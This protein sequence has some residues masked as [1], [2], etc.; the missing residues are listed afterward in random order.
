[1]NLVPSI[2][3]RLSPLPRKVWV[4]RPRP[5]VLPT[6]KRKRHFTKVVD[7]VDLHSLC[8]FKQEVVLAHARKPFGRHAFSS[9]SREA[10]R[11]FK[12][13]TDAIKQ[14]IIYTV[15]DYAHNRKE[16]Q[17]S[18]K[19]AV[20]NSPLSAETLR[21]S[22]ENGAEDAESGEAISPTSASS[23]A[24]ARFG[25]PIALFLHALRTNAVRIPGG[26]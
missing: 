3:A 4:V 16:K 24:H 22:T 11:R 25:K 26:D 21:F 1:M 13:I 23:A 15:D 10:D 2:S 14:I 8:L 20:K 5:S 19:V 6:P 12:Q 18:R 9:V 17:H 7:L